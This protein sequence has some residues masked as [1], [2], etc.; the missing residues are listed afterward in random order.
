MNEHLR[1][2]CIAAIT[3]VGFGFMLGGGDAEYA[4]KLGWTFACGCLCGQYWESSS[5]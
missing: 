3:G 2:F 4:F 1:R 5:K